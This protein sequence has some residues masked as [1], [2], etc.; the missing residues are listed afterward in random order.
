[1]HDSDNKTPIE[2]CEFEFEDWTRDKSENTL[3][4]R[5]Y[6]NHDG[7]L[8]FKLRDPSASVELDTTNMV[9]KIDGNGMTYCFAIDYWYCRQDR[10]FV[11][12]TSDY[13]IYFVDWT[14]VNDLC[15]WQGRGSVV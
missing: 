8:L 14:A 4:L 2:M 6:D 12:T 10:Y 3:E 1:M 5:A 9:I 7:N 13:E 15:A 11:H